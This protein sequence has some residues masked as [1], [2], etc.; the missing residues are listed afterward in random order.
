[1]NSRPSR[2]GKPFATSITIGISLSTV[3]GAGAFAGLGPYTL[4]YSFGNFTDSLVVAP[5]GTVAFQGN[6]DP[7]LMNTTPEIVRREASRLLETMRGTR[8]H[9]FNLGHGIM[10]EAKI[11]NMEALVSTVRD[12]R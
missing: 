9:I 5:G 4:N 1:M 11:E 2:A 8:G 3:T 7:V 6:L 10:P 12:W